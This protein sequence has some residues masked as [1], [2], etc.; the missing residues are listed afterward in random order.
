[1]YQKS[2]AESVPCTAVFQNN[3]PVNLPW[4]SS[5]LKILKKSKDISWAEF[6]ENPTHGNLNY[7]LEEQNA[8]ENEEIRSKVKYEKKIISNLK[9]N[10]KLLLY[11]YYYTM[12]Y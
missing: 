1:M 5:K 6:D 10:C 2:V 8:Y 7:S 9:T 11:M 12:L 3:R 4:N